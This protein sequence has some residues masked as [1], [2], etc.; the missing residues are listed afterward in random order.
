[1]I[2]LIG[3]LLLLKQVFERILFSIGHNVLLLQATL[4]FY[5][6]LK[7]QKK[8]INPWFSEGELCIL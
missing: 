3:D 5:I 7:K 2:L 6:I 1:M 8:S 4:I